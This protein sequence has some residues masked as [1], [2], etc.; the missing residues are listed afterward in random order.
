MYH[1]NLKFNY[2]R[3]IN[4]FSK[5]P[6]IYSDGFNLQ[7]I[8]N[9]F[10]INF[11]IDVGAFTGSYAQSVRRFGYKGKILSFEPILNSHK[12]LKD[13]SKNDTNWAVYKNIALGEKKSTK[14]IFVSGKSDSSSFLKIK[15][16]HLKLEPESKIIKKEKVEVDKLDDIIKNYK[17]I[18]LKKTILKIDTQ[19]YEFEVLKGSTNILKKVKLLQIELS[20]T[21][22]YE[23]QKSHEKIIH[24]LK[25][26]KFKT[27]CLIPGFK[28]KKNGKLL[29]YDII[30]YK[31]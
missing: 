4:K 30:M 25:K 14:H 18:D 1:N 10:K 31:S 7:K 28:N 6:I 17:K 11:I 13:N 21:E 8:L 16:E 23:G 15:K 19:G 12:I 9:H 20:L 27:W 5:Y 3:L 2:R 24:H 22:L 26:M 29:Q